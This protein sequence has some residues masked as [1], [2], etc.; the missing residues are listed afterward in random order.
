M[1]K[2]IK[3]KLADIKR[4][5]RFWNYLKHKCSKMKGLKFHDYRFYITGSDKK[6]SRIFDWFWEHG[7]ILDEYDCNVNLGNKCLWIT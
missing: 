6:L 4:K 3:M 1:F 2:W 5:E 7:A